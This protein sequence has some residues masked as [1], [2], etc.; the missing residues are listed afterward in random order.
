[1]KAIKY[2]EKKTYILKVWN[3]DHDILRKAKKINLKGS[4]NE[5]LVC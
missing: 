1:M 4:E 2:Q 3:I 5:C